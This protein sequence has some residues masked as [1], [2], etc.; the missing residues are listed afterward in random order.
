MISAWTY[1]DAGWSENQSAKNIKESAYSPQL[2]P[3]PEPRWR[4]SLSTDQSGGKLDRLLCVRNQLMYMVAKERTAHNAVDKGVG[5][6]HTRFTPFLLASQQNV[7]RGFGYIVYQVP[8]QR[9]CDE[10]IGD[11]RGN[12]PN[13]HNRLNLWDLCEHPHI[14]CCNSSSNACDCRTK[15]IVN[16]EH[17]QR[18]CGNIRSWTADMITM[19][20]V[21]GRHRMRTWI[22]YAKTHC[23]TEAV[24]PWRQLDDICDLGWM[25]YTVRTGPA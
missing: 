13:E 17:R 10:K 16:I 14:V 11:H 15:P 18:N 3:W 8:Y 12:H 23:T 1:I 2:D 21:R 5:D 7:S 20:M 19:T 4:T 24:M 6:L 25:F 9:N 22:Q